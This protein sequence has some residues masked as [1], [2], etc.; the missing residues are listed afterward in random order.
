[1]SEEEVLD[2][3]RKNRFRQPELNLFMYALIA[4]AVGFVLY[5][6]FLLQCFKAP[7]PPKVQTDKKEK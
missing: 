6:A 3:L 7:A 2:W 1:M 4:I 5:T